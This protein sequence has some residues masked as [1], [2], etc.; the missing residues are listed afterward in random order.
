MNIKKIKCIILSSLMIFSFTVNTLVSGVYYL[1]DVNSEMSSHSYW[2]NESEVLMSYEEIND[3]IWEINNPEE[4]KDNKAG[5]YIP[6]L[7][8]KDG[9]Y[10]FVPSIYYAEGT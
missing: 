2:T 6:S 3:V 7:K 10:M 4:I 1:P 8:E 5:A 9:K